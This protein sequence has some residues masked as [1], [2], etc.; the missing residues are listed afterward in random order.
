MKIIAVHFFS[1]M[2]NALFCVTITN[3]CMDIL[4]QKKYYDSGVHLSKPSKT[5]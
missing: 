4:L 2:Y 1:F 5:C 3:C